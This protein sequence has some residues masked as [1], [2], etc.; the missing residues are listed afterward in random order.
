MRGIRKLISLV[1]VTLALGACE[2]TTFRSSVPVYPV[3]VVIDTRLGEFVHFQP[4]NLYSYL[5]V[6]KDGYFLNGRYIQDRVLTDAYGY[7]GVLAYISMNGYDA[8]DLA[9]PYCA[10]KG[11]KSSCEVDGFFATCPACGEQYDLA[12]G[13][14]VPQ[15]GIAQ[16]TLRRLNVIV[17][18]SK[19]TI[20]QRQ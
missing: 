19:I 4:S 16:E 6:N 15:K 12:S 2:G 7:G 10:S 5:V 18:D 3:R 11:Y 13:T 1:C 20:T 17:S 9:C 14:A 8:Y